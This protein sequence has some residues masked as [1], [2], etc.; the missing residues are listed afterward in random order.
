MSASTHEVV[1]Q[2]P[3][4]LGHDLA[5][6]AALLEGLV[7]HGAGWAADDLHRLGRLGGQAEPQRWA[8]EA[9][10]YEPRLLTHD[11]YGHRLDEVEF[12]PSWH[13]LMDVAGSE[14]LAGGAG[15]APPPGGPP[16]PPGGGV[17]PRPGGGG[18]APPRPPTPRAGSP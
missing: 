14:G 4:L 15:G 11:R 10:R 5:D 2:P 16:G 7:G 3:P 8:E 9:N 17:P 18:G 12:H 6:D 1:N 13:R